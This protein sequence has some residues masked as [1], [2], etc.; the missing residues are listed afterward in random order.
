MTG[1]VDIK[2]SSA[3]RN[4]EM[5]IADERELDQTRGN[6]LDLVACHSEIQQ[7]DHPPTL[8]RAVAGRWKIR[9]C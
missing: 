4:D 3:V 6:G 2:A 9:P 8:R 1:S 5:W 7:A